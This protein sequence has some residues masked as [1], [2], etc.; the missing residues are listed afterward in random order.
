MNKNQIGQVMKGIKVLILIAVIL[1]LLFGG[2][3]LYT[4]LNLLAG[5]SVS[6]KTG[7]ELNR[8]AGTFAEIV[9]IASAV[10]WLLRIIMINIKKKDTSL[11]EWFR[12]LYLV[13]QKYHLI[14]GIITLVIAFIHGL[15]FLLF[16]NVK[17]HMGPPGGHD[18]TLNFYSGIVS[19]FALCVLA[20]L[21]W[22]HQTK[23]KTKQTLPTKRKHK[24]AALVFGLLALIHIY[25]I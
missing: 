20:L 3:A 18:N 19:F 5:K 16:R 11:K 7:E 21:G 2:D 4:T 23:R 12:Q 24:I 22:Y 6:F 14:L 25:I 9:G 13:F 15:Y 1:I 10:I 17:T 8:Q